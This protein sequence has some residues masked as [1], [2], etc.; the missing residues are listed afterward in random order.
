MGRM[1][2]ACWDDY[3]GRFNGG[4]PDGRGLYTWKNDQ[5]FKGEWKAEGPNG[6]G[7]L[8]FANGGS[9]HLQE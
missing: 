4:V 5:N 8:K 6:P 7:I 2:Y 1:Q 3:S 9:V